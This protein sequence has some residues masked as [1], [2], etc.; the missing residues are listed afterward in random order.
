MDIVFPY[1]I[2][3]KLP[4][5]LG[6]IPAVRK[7]VS[8]AL[9][10]SGFGPKFAFRTEIIVDAICNNAIS[11]GSEEGE[12][13]EVEVACEVH[14]DRVEVIVKDKGG[15]EPNI[16]RLRDA[17]GR[18]RIEPAPDADIGTPGM[19]LEIVKLLSETIELNV[20]SNNLTSIHVVS[21]REDG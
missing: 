19:G 7:F 12:E 11:Y 5:D 13:S 21:R 4:S 6:V 18:S 1:T 10:V 3:I 17:I 20:D 9:L 15:S 16:E 14:A 8:E 2:S